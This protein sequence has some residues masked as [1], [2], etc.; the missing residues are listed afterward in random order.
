MWLVS[1]DGSVDIATVYGYGQDGR[2]SF[3]GRGQEI[4]LFSTASRQISGHN[5]PLIQWIPGA[6]LWGDKAASA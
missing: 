5:Y 3:V 4:I 2:I 1:Q 6:F